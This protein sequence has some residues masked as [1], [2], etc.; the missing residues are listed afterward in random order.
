MAQWVPRGPAA[1]QAGGARDPL[2]Q[3]LQA[4]REGPPVD[5]ADAVPA[6]TR[7]GSLC[8]NN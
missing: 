4:A 2:A 8:T 1:G 3:P 7:G 5:P 6:C